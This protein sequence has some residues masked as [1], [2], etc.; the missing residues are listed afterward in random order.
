LGSCSKISDYNSISTKIGAFIDEKRK[1]LKALDIYVQ[2]RF[3]ERQALILPHQRQIDEIA[4]KCNDKVFDFNNETQKS[5]GKRA[6][7]FEGGFEQFQP[8]FTELDEF[9][10]REEVIIQ[11][12]GASNCS[13][14]GIQGITGL[15]GVRGSIGSTGD[16]GVCGTYVTSSNY[17]QSWTTSTDNIKEPEISEDED[18]ALAK[19]STLRNLLQKYVNKLESL[20]TVIRKLEYEKRRLTLVKN[21]IEDDRIFKLDLPKL[22]AFGF[23]DLSE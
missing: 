20:K 16:Q 18:E 17:G 3:D 2:G 15:M 22:S 6:L 12:V 8:N 7:D 13:I 5:L 21:S 19:M 14:T 23:E 10:K 4:K 1:F 11:G 9:L